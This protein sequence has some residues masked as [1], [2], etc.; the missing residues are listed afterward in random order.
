[1]KQFDAVRLILTTT[2]TDRDIGLAAG[3]SK[4][5]V[6]RYRR[7]AMIKKLSWE[8]VGALDPDAVHRLFNRPAQGGKPKRS[9]DLSV[10]HEQLQNKGMTLQ[11]LWED[12]RREDPHN[13]LS[14]SHLAAK[15]QRHRETL[16]T[17]MRQHHTPGERVFVDYSGLRPH[18][19]DPATQQKVPVELFVAVL[20]ASSL[21][22]ATCTPSQKVPDFIRAHVAM[23]DYFGGVPEVIVPDNLKSAV[24]LA[25]RIPTIQRTY[26][27][28]AR[29]YGVA[30]LPARP[31]KPRDKGSVEA[32][33]KYAQQRILARLRHRHFYSID[34]LNAAISTLLEE[35][36]DRPMVKDGLSRRARFE[37]L[38]R[39]ALKPLP[40][41]P[42]VYA[43]WVAIP[44]VPKDYHVAVEGHFYSVPHDL[45]GQRLDAR[46]TDTTVEILRDRKRVAYHARSA[47]LGGHTTTSAHQPEAHRAQAQ[48]SPEGM[49]AWAKSAGPQLLRFVKHQLDRPQPFLGMPACDALRTLAHAHGTEKLDEVAGRAL[50]LHSP[51]ITTLKRLLDNAVAS[52]KKPP[53]PRNSNARGA[54][55]HAEVVQC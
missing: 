52:V 27:D 12:Y 38:E 31:Y 11:L 4:T 42:Y 5:T 21:M 2:L 50:D 41:V 43:E 6:G 44:K 26:A 49:L 16:P 10:L 32:G 25:S 54:R 24:T 37:A 30:I 47:V 19:I 18:Y 29:H 33:V 36:N 15:L 28:L 9:P 55:Y 20:G 22:F 40:P 7:I 35:A 17:V 8:K 23:L 45:I 14:Y 1:M 34:E 46:I 51:K 39:S 3:M 53:A 13:T 48:R